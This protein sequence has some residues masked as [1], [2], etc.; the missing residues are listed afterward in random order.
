[1]KTE[2]CYYLGYISKTIGFEGSLLALFEVGDPSLYHDLEA[3]LV[4][5]DGKLVPFFI[6]EISIRKK[7]KEVVLD[8]ED[9]TTTEEAR[10]LCNRK[11]FVHQKHLK[12]NL[13][14]TGFQQQNVIGFSVF[15]KKRN[16]LGIIEEILEYP[17]NPVFSIQKGKHEILLPVADEFIKEVDLDKQQIMIDPPDGLLDIYI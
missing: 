12:H 11:I 10:F 5:I 16:Y 2:D 1:M 4:L 17:G 13:P 9:I 15:D 3:F 14:Q 6:E 7:D 8:L